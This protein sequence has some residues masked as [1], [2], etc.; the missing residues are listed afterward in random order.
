MKTNLEYNGYRGS[1]EVSPE[2]N[3]L[4]GKILGINDV[5]T[6]EAETVIDLRQAFITAVDD[7]LTT[8]RDL[9]KEPQRSSPLRPRNMSRAR[10]IHPAA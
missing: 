2:D 10:T 5:V 7:Y 3:C 8:C 9:G 4:F 6:Y 1:I